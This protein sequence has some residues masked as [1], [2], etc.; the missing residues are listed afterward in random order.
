MG[1]G[2]N[3]YK[4]GQGGRKNGDLSGGRE[5]AGWVSERGE[6]LKRKT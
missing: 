2:A 1:K 4:C 5:K 3:F 6:C